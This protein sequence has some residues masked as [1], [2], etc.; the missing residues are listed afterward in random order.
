MGTTLVAVLRPG[1]HDVDLPI[2][3][4]NQGGTRSA[5]GDGRDDGRSG[6]A[7]AGRRH[8]GANGLVALPQA[9]SAEPVAFILTRP[10]ASMP[11]VIRS[12]RPAGVRAEWTHC[13]AVQP[14]AGSK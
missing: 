12:T 4:R 2:E 8:R 14:L 7:S 13:V 5:A 9:T 6:P 10:W 3:G 1:Q 11:T